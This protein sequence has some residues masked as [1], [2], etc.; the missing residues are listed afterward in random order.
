MT[1]DDFFPVFADRVRRS[2]ALRR[3]AA[4]NHPSVAPQ[5]RVEWRNGPPKGSRG[6]S[7]GSGYGRLLAATALA[8]C[9]VLLVP[10]IIG[11]E[12]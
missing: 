2:E 3:A 5:T 9:A 11:G 4:V 12:R 6:Q 8:V 10:C 1:T 7:G